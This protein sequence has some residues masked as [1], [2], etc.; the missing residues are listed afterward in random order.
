MSVTMFPEVGKQGNI[1]RK[2][3]VSATIFPEVDKQGNTGIKKHK[4]S[5]TMFLSLARILEKSHDTALFHTILL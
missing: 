4:L 3:S 1:D 5:V 2:R